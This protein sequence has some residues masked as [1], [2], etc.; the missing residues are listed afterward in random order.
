[1]N[2]KK[3]YKQALEEAEKAIQ[4]AKEESQRKCE[5]LMYVYAEELIAIVRK[6]ILVAKLRGENEICFAPHYDKKSYWLKEY[7]GEASIILD[8]RFFTLD[9]EVLHDFAYSLIDEGYSVNF[10][11]GT[12]L[13]VYTYDK[14][15]VSWCDC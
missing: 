9:A 13:D 14:I 5:E 10:D 2:A 8:D 1:M 4:K 7:Y 12:D 3:S 15:T 11:N 6:A